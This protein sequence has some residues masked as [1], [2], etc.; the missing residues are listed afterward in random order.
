MGTQTQESKPMKVGIVGSRRYTNKTKIKDFIWMLKQKFGD[1]LEIVSGGC[2]TG[3]DI[4]A[5]KAAK[6]LEVKYVEFP[7]QFEQ[8]NI[9]CHLPAYM[10]GKGFHVGLYFAR[11][12]QIA[13]YSDIVVAFIPKGVDDSNG[14]M[15]TINYA[16][17]F[18]KKA[19]II[20]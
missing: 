8:H 2:R 5:K 6:D 13:E 11:N 4:Y 14:S 1:D 3:A 19:T 12:K 10:Y 7:P 20:D 15:S 9:H 17:K 16:K 18:N